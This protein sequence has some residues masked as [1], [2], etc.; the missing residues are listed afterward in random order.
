MENLFLLHPS[1]VFLRNEALDTGYRDVDLRQALAAGV[2]R[3]IRHGV[4]VDASAWA[5]ASAEQRHLLLADGVLLSHQSPLAL[6]HLSAAVAHGFQTYNQ[7]LSKVHVLCLDD[8][9]GRSHAD[10]V[11]HRT[12]PRRLEDVELVAHRAVV[13]Q[14]RAA[15]EAA[16]LTDVRHGLVTLDSAL[17][18]GATSLDQLEAE[19]ARIEGNRGT[20]SLR[21][22]VKLARPG[23]ESVGETLGRFLMWRNGIPEPL[24]QWEVR[25]ADGVLVAR[26]DWAW[27]HG[28]LCGEFDG[29]EKYTRYLREGESV[30]DA[31]IREKEREDLVRELT[32]LRMFRMTWRDLD[33]E[34]ELQTAARI[35]RAF[36]A[37][38]SIAS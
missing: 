26:L 36:R 24:L 15:L 5:I 21:L 35:K 19:Y 37:P 23:S 31:V 12:T 13:P 33:R 2:I 14:T 11:Y 1:P 7:D 28:G 38:R 17:N 34:R 6:S 18:L 25:D 3:R 4:Y 32:D 8:S 30:S 20:Q 16:S 29:R 10:V 9:I 22:T 27:P